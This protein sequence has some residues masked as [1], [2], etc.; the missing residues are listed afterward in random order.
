VRTFLLLCLLLSTSLALDEVPAAVVPEV[1]APPRPSGLERAGRD[2]AARS[3]AACGLVHISQT[4][5]RL[6]VTLDRPLYRPGDDIRLAVWSLATDGLVPAGTS[7]TVKLLDPR[8]TEVSADALALD[9]GTAHVAL[10]LAEDAA[11]GTWTLSVEAPGATTITHT[12]QVARFGT[13]RVDK[14]LTF[15]RDAYAPGDEVRATVEL[16]RAGEPL[17]DHPAT[18]QLRVEGAPL[19]PISLWTD[20]E[21]RATVT[22]RLPPEL[23]RPDVSLTVFVDD[24]G[25]TESTSRPVPVH[26]DQVHLAWFPEGGSLVH[27][28][29]SRVYFEITDAHGEPVDAAGTVTDDRGQAVAAFQTWVDGRGHFTFTPEPGRSYQAHLGRGVPYALPMPLDQGCVLRH[30]DDLDGQQRA[31]RVEVACTAR[32]EVGLVAA[33]HGRLIDRASVRVDGR[34]PTTVHLRSGHPAL[35]GAQGVA[36]VTLFDHRR[37]PLA[38]RLVYR[39]RGQ[40]LT[41]TLTPDRADYAPGEQVALTVRTTDPLGR[42]VPATVAVSVVDD[43]LFTFADDDQHDMVSRVLLAAELREPI[44]GVGHLLGP[45]A[46]DDA[47]LGLDLV[48][49]TRGWRRFERP[50]PVHRYYL[51][52]EAVAGQVLTYRDT[53]RTVPGGASVET[54]RVFAEPVAPSRL[55]ED[56]RGTVL[57]APA[58]HT[59]EL[60]VAR[61]GFTLSEDA[62]GTGYRAVAE[63]VGGGWVGTGEAAFASTLAGE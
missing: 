63:G 28:L 30:V 46:G 24:G 45:D 38:E 27:G 5:Q 21:G 2:A 22:V 7:A 44:D 17:V 26:L 20:A 18:A 11:G 32:R 3:S 12:L 57:W 16:A 25:G 41:V 14:R 23:G 40:G 61:I 43:A 48:L 54:V 29:S 31:V 62:T 15:A 52:A 55:S 19:P 9:G 42:P 8:G 13:P 37:H 35:S 58:V 10:Q 50:R 51:D 36:L 47:G 56:F 34:R 49:G 39:N 59:G 53:V 33:Q 6:H 4:L 1:A 60:G